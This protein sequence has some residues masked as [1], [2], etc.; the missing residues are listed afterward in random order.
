MDRRN[1]FKQCGR[2]VGFSVLAAGSAALL[3]R[4]KK[5]LSGQI[6]VS[7]GICRGCNTFAKCNLPQAQSAKRVIGRQKNG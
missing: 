1:F 6:C 3:F 7:K 2:A 5:K 4:P